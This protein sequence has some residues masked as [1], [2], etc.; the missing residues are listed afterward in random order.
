MKSARELGRHYI[1][2]RYP[3]VH[4]SGAPHEAYDGEVSGRAVQC[5]QVMLEFAKEFIEK[6][7][8]RT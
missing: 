5:A 6:L 4:P 7:K 1:L 3:N 8:R 2:A